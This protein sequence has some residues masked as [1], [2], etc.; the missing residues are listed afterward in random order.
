MTRLKLFLLG[1]ALVTWD[2]QALIISRRATRSLLF[3]LASQRKAVSRS[4][5]CDLFWPDSLE[6]EARNNLRDL[7]AKLKRSLPDPNLLITHNDQVDLD[8]AAIYVDQHDFTGQYDALQGVPWN[9][10]EI[11]PLPKH[12]ETALENLLGLWKGAR[13]L[14]EARL[15]NS[16]TLDNWLVY[17]DESLTLIRRTCLDRLAAHFLR[18]G[19]TKAAVECLVTLKGYD[20]SNP[21]LHHRLISALMDGGFLFEARKSLEGSIHYFEKQ[22]AVPLPEVILQDKETL[23]DLMEQ[24]Q[25]APAP[26]QWSKNFSLDLR[27]VGRQAEF[28]ALQQ[29]FSR[30]GCVILQGESGIGK[31]RLVKE[32]YEKSMPAAQLLYASSI[33]TDQSLPFQTVINLLRT[34][35]SEEQWKALPNL[36][37][38]FLTLLI[39]DLTLLKPG[40]IIPDRPNSTSAENLVYEAV[41]ALLKIVAS[42]NRLML[43]MDDAQWA[44][45]SSLSLLQYLVNHGFFQVNGVLVIV[46]QT[47]HNNVRLRS[48]IK[49]VSGLESTTTLTLQGLDENAVGELVRQVDPG[50]ICPAFV[51]QLTEYTSGNP[52][53]VLETIAS[54]RNENPTGV[55]GDVPGDLPIGGNIQ[56]LIERRLGILPEESRRLVRAAAVLGEILQPQALKSIVDLPDAQFNKAFRQLIQSELLIPEVAKAPSNPQFRFKHELERQAILSTL[57]FYGAMNLHARAA[58]ALQVNAAGQARS[59]A[60]RIA[61]HYQAAGMLHEALQWWLQAAQYSWTIFANSAAKEAYQ[62][63]ENIILQNQELIPDNDVYDFSSQYALF[64][65]ESG[66]IEKLEQICQQSLE[67][68]EERKY[69]GLIGSAFLHMS[70]QSFATANYHE[71][72]SYL[73][74][75]ETYLAVS[76][77][78]QA[79]TAL[80]VLRGLLLGMVDRHQEAIQSYNTAL[81]INQS[82]NDPAVLLT[83]FMAHYYK[84]NV[85]F[86]MGKFKEGRIEIE[87]GYERYR[88]VLRPFHQMR[89]HYAFSYFYFQLCD[90][91]ELRQHSEKGYELAKAMDSKVNVQY[92]HLLFSSLE[93]RMGN[94][95]KSYMYI[96]EVLTRVE[97]LQNADLFMHAH[98]LLGEIYLLLNDFPRAESE[99]RIAVARPLKWYAYYQCQNRLV[100]ALIFQGKL[101]EAE[102]ILQTIMDYELVTEMQGVYLESLLNQAYINL[103]K[104]KK[105]SASYIIDDLAKRAKKEEMVELIMLEKFS[106]MQIAA[107]RRQYAIVDTLYSEI[108]SWSLENGVPWPYLTATPFWMQ[109]SQKPAEEKAKQLAVSRQWIAQLEPLCQ[110]PAFRDSFNAAKAM[111]LP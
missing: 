7:I 82:I 18:I 56:R 106:Q 89:A 3:Y 54:L 31:T 4:A 73:N 88:H 97:E 69:P 85:L 78:P 38:N 23:L 40:L 102:Q 16:I 81:S 103:L 49:Q 95:D 101:D 37:A 104:G 93:N 58:E 28:D 75:A 42:K 100:Y 39:P 94:L 55:L 44:D 36:W 59:L 108:S 25:S 27:L 57:S 105:D 62:E 14:G 52:Y 1:Q 17:T 92:F 53:L 66:D 2:D 43:V 45:I 87:T 41:M 72:L 109:F 8:H 47:N 80:F 29:T 11:T 12:L 91:Q 107:D 61:T 90:F 35:I 24:E 15:V 64:L 76:S 60:S 26:S 30:G 46:C 13:F 9:Y 84:C 21:T 6:K 34:N 70:Y 86:S 77:H 5:L 63:A 79:M 19:E 20:E 110:S 10:A 83:N 67:W 32:L 111:W 22:L 98:F 48:V 68:G 33:E 51:H 99:F 96:Q 71:G 50:E 65:Y 74:K